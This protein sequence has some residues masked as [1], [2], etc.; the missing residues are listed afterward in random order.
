MRQAQP[1]IIHTARAE[2]WVRSIRQLRPEFQPPAARQSLSNREL[3][4]PVNKG[5]E[6]FFAPDPCNTHSATW[7]RAIR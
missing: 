7:A 4:A 2:A 5:L 3:L 1:L 6:A